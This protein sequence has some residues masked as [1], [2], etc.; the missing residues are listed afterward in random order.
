ME[1]TI[2][3]PVMHERLA[4][5]PLPAGVTLFDPGLSDKESH[6]RPESLPLDEKAARGYVHS[7]LA[8]G[9][10]FK[11]PRDLSRYLSG[12]GDDFYSGTTQSIHTE[13][14]RRERGVAPQSDGRDDMIRAQSLLLLAWEFEERALE[15]G[16]MDSGLAAQAVALQSSLSDEDDEELVNVMELSHPSEMRLPLRWIAILYGRIQADLA[17]NRGAK[18]G[19]DVAKYIL[20]GASVVQVASALYENG[21]DYVNQMND[22]LSKWMTDKGYASVGDFR[23]KVSQKDAADPFEFERPASEV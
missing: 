2:L 18:T 5:G 6:L 14:S 22:D 4:A 13:L 9:E 12:A 3:F 16:D 23:G 10:Q 21:L 19:Y 17:G 8:F 7:S 1:P 20:A 15:L 11:D